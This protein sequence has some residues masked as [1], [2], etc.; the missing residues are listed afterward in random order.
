[1]I[2]NEIDLLKSNILGVVLRFSYIKWQMIK[3]EDKYVQ[4]S[5]IEGV[6]VRLRDYS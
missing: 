6:W 1:M 3:D 4:R 2:Q 5:R